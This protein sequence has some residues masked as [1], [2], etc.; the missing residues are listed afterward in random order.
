MSVAE[1]ASGGDCAK[2][3]G[4]EGIRTRFFPEQ[5]CG[6]ESCASNDD[7]HRGDGIAHRLDQLERFWDIEQDCGGD[8]EQGRLL[9]FDG[10]Y[11]FGMRQVAP[12]KSHLPAV[13]FQYVGDHQSAQLMEFAL[14]SHD[15]RCAVLR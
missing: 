4:R 10:I 1:L 11:D 2:K 5:V 15:H 7:R 12:E 9:L 6:F 3:V 8:A 14:H 13:R